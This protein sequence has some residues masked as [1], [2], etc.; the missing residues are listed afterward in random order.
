V[1]RKDIIETDNEFEK[2]RMNHFICL[3]LKKKGKETKKG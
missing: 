2:S 3:D 1:I